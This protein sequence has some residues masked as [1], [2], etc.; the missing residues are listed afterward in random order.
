MTSSTVDNNLMFMFVTGHVS[1]G[2]WFLGWSGGASVEEKIF[3]RLC[4]GIPPFFL[5]F[6]CEFWTMNSAGPW[7]DAAPVS[8][9]PLLLPSGECKYLPFVAY[10][11]SQ[12]F[13][14]WDDAPDWVFMVRSVTS[15]G[16]E[17]CDGYFLPLDV[18]CW[19]LSWAS[20]RELFSS[21]TVGASNSALRFLPV[22]PY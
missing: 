10:K 20:S 6:S 21:E 5:I 12:Y 9:D 14:V 2:F 8:V 13:G 7:V 4:T 15:F 18:H 19:S 17:H 3:V 1:W 16:L 11:P 22:P